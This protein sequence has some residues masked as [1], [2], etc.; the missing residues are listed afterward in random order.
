M[1]GS[2]FSIVCGGTLISTKWAITAAHCT[3]GAPLDGTGSRVL[4]G[5]HEI[6]SDADKSTRKDFI[7][8]ELINHQQYDDNTYENDITLL[9]LAGEAVYTAYIQPACLPSQGVQIPV[10]TNCWISG[11]GETQAA[12]T[13]VM[14]QASVPI[15]DNTDCQSWSGLR[16]LDNMV[17]AGYKEGGIDSCQGDS[18]GPLVCTAGNS[19]VLQGVTSH[20]IGCAEPNRPGVYTRMSE[21]VSWTEQQMSA[22]STDTALFTIP[23]TA[24]GSVI[25]SE[26]VIRLPVNEE[27]QIYADSLTCGWT[28]QPPTGSVSTTISF[29]GERFHIEANTAS[30]C[31]DYLEVIKTGQR[32]NL[33]CGATLPAD[34]VISG[35][36]PFTLQFVSDS[37]VG[38]EGFAATVLFTS[39]GP[40]P[41]TTSPQPGTTTTTSTTTVGPTTTPGARQCGNRQSRK[42]KRSVALIELLEPDVRIV[43]GT[44]AERG[45]WPWQIGYA[46]MRGSSFSIVCGGTLISTKWAITAAHCTVGAPLDGTG[47]RVLLGAHEIGSD[48]DKS[49]RKD[50][51]VSELINHQQYDDNTYENDI[52]LLKLAG[53]AVYTA[54]IQPA[55]LPSQGVQIPVGTNCWISGWGETQAA[56]T[57]VMQQASVPI[58]DNTDCQ[59]WSGLRI[60]DNMV[61]AG[62][63][64]GGIDSCQG[65][66]G[67]PLVCTAGNSFVLQGVTSHG[68]GC[69]EPNRPGVY[70]RMSEF[71][72]WTEQ[73]M[74]APSTDTALFTI[75]MTACGSV[76][77]SEQVIRLPVNEE[78]QIYADS[79]TCSWTIEPTSTITTISFTGGRFHIEANTASTCYDYL[80]VTRDGQRIN[81][82][83]GTT[84]PNDFV[85]SGQD[86][87]TLQFISDASVGFEGFAAMISF[88]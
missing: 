16:I 63:K 41:P 1:R 19:F 82:F 6:G 2:S 71:V 57:N 66:S 84:L 56:D 20:G 64:E 24:C 38:F 34:L 18:G 22:P 28:I 61:C 13:N 4:L 32:I 65:D 26:Q 36:E 5:A 85:V 70:T 43:G 46:A 76:I 62:Y 42:V 80:E 23:M 74:S 48:A 7:V 60:L 83:C 9:K 47:S 29:I 33:L 31:Y 3:V 17:C 49:T 68:I 69:A 77:N 30:T 88:N 75:P 27:T 12:D 40:T 21:F 59:S 39:G 51:I 37:S 72:S 73:Q 35:Q 10:G 14:Q 45:D 55:C 52:T 11:W 54:Y 81:L 53:E 8:S 87:F 58:V 50:F 15:V 44:D 67:G 86:P 25:N 79:L 78:T